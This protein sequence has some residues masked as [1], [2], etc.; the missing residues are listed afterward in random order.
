MP[1]KYP[2]RRSYALINV[3]QFAVETLGMTAAQVGI[4]MRRLAQRAMLGDSEFVLS[5]KFVHRFVLRRSQISR[6]I[7]TATERRVVLERCGRACVACRA[8][9]QLELD[10]IIPLS[11]GG[12]DTPN[13]LQ[14]LCRSCNLRK[15]GKLD[16]ELRGVA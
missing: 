2:Y 3:R 4:S 15:G 5:H 1:D 14:I 7:W 9:S 16:G 10:H 12:A 13:N 6:R 11:R 8:S